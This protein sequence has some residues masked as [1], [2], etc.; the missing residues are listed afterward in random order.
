MKYFFLFI[1]LFAVSFALLNPSQIKNPAVDRNY[2]I[3]TSNDQNQSNLVPQDQWQQNTSNIEKDFTTSNDSWKYNERLQNKLSSIRQYSRVR[4]IYVENS[5]VSVTYQQSSKLFWLFD[6][7]YPIVITKNSNDFN[8]EKPWWTMF[9]ND[10]SQQLAL[11]TIS[12]NMEIEDLNQELNNNLQLM[13]DLM[14]KL[15]D[16]QSSVI[17]KIG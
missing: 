4:N 6:V 9:T 5:S 3:V 12:P 13:S 8:I 14:K 1:L 2:H 7:N 10:N 17:Q 11:Q 16:T 15:N